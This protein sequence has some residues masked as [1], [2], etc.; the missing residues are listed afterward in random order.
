[1]VLL[2]DD[3][4]PDSM[5]IDDDLLDSPLLQDCD[6]FDDFS[7]SSDGDKALLTDGAGV[8]VSHLRLF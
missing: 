8:G 6:D 3:D 4:D 2:D 5:Q 7:D 1:M